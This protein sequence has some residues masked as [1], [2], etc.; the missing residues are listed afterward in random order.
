MDEGSISH[1]ANTS[2]GRRVDAVNK[3]SPSLL[4]AVER[5]RLRAGLDLNPEHLPFEGADLITAW[6][7][8]WIDR[9]GKP[10]V[11]ILQLSIPATSRAVIESKSLKLYLGSFSQTPFTSAYDVVRTLESDLAVTAGVPVPVDMWS[12]TQAQQA[13]LGVSPGECLDTLKIGSR[14]VVPEPEL[15]KVVE[16]GRMV[17]ESVHTNLFRSLCPVTGQPDM[18]SIQITYSGQR[19]DHESLLQYLVSYREYCGFHEH[20]VERIFVDITARC[21]PRDLSVY[22]R[23]LRRGGIDINPFRSTGRTPPARSRLVRQ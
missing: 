18:A 8:S 17:A 19:I 10:E 14:H 15:L 20:C 5:W 6:E 13:G 3:Y 9:S 22:G 11:G 7:L 23:F 12:L 4:Q 1:F 21:R 16:D 2:L